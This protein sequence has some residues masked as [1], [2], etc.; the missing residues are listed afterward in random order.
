MQKVVVYVLGSEMEI[1]PETR[2]DELQGCDELKGESG[3][4]FWSLGRNRATPVRDI[5]LTYASHGDK[6][7]QSLVFAGFG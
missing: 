5:C 3:A 2:V 7:G 6:D 1:L 4:S